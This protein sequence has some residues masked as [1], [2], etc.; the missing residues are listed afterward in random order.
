MSSLTSKSKFIP[1]L[2]IVLILK[3]YVHVVLTTDQ[4]LLSVLIISIANSTFSGHF[5]SFILFRIFMEITIAFLNSY[6]LLLISLLVCMLY[7]SPNRHLPSSMKWV[8]VSKCYNR[9]LLFISAH[10]IFVSIS[11]V[12]FQFWYTILYTHLL[13]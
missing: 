5:N 2:T 6:Y 3:S 10:H 4:A 7:Y 1:K 13:S 8:A 9:L 11:I 12:T